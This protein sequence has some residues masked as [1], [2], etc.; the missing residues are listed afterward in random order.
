M[1]TIT[2]ILIFS[3]SSFKFGQKN[4]QKCVFHVKFFA[5]HDPG[6]RKNYKNLGKPEKSE[7]RK[8]V[9]NL[10]IA[11]AKNPPTYKISTTRQ[12][13]RFSFEQLWRIIFK[14]ASF[15]GK[16]CS[17]RIFLAQ[18]WILRKFLHRL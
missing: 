7:N 14:K 18:I 16:F 17:F 8:K 2:K 10:E 4:T 11:V 12:K 15:P 6:V 5:E 3:Y 9:K 13:F 1:F